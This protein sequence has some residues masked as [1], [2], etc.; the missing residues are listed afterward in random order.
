MSIDKS[1]REMWIANSRV[2]LALLEHISPNMLKAQTPG[3]GYTVAQHF[4]HITESSKYWAMKISSKELKDLPDLSTSDDEDLENYIVE[5]D[6]E[7]IKN[8]IAKTD[9]RIL[10]LVEIAKDKG[11]LPHFSIDAYLIHMMIHNAHH[12]GMI[13]LALKTSAYILPDD[14]L[15]WGPLRGA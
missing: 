4:A 7:R 14:E 1:V 9:S 11:E 5:Y 3:G 13:M 10:E 6:L 12:R 8:V 2:N 15:I